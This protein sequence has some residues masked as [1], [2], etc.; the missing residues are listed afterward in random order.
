MWY[1]KILAG[2]ECT[3]PVPELFTFC[4][5]SFGLRPKLKVESVSKFKAY[6]ETLSHKLGVQQCIKGAG[7][8]SISIF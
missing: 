7:Q 3:Y 2:F 6:F 8:F 1:I 5:I 4:A